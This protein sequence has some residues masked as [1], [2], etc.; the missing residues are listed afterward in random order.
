MNLEN[1]VENNFELIFLQLDKF[2]MQLSTSQ[3]VSELQTIVERVSFSEIYKQ[4]VADVQATV[5]S[6]R[7]LFSGE[8]SSEM[9]NFIVWIAENRALPLMAG[10]TGRAFIDYSMRGYKDVQE[11]K[12]ITAIPLRDAARQWVIDKLR[13][14][15][16]A[17][18][19]IT[20]EVSTD[21]VAGFKLHDKSSTVDKSLAT[22]TADMAPEYVSQIINARSTP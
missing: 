20:F 5:S 12:F 9:L 17:P 13:E 6:V 8:V 21:I 19:R 22:F 16:P 3:V 2:V 1:N 11:I 14:R 10:D 15:Y 18:A 4:Q 7:T